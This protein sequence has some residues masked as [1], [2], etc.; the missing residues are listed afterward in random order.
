METGNLTV[1]VT[2]THGEAGNAV[3]E[4]ARIPPG[5]RPIFARLPALA[6]NTAALVIQVPGVDG[7]YAPV[8]GYDEDTASA[9]PLHIKC[10]ATNARVKRMAP[11]AFAG[12]GGS[13]KLAAYQSDLSTAVAQA[14]GAEVDD[15]VVKIDCRRY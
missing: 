1:N 3:S 6:E 12:F 9:D 14:V 5:W 2:F 11:E 7:S 13:F 4:V 10:A 15:V 8:D